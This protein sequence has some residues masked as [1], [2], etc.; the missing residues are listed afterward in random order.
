MSW[1]LALDLSQRLIPGSDCQCKHFFQ[2]LLPRVKSLLFQCV[3]R[4]CCWTDYSNI[5]Y[6]LLTGKITCGERLGERFENGLRMTFTSWG[7]FCVRNPRPVILFSVVFIAMC[8]SGFVYIKATTNPVDLW[9]APSSQARKEKEY[10]DKHFGP[11]FRTEQLIIQA[12]NSHP[13]IYSPYPSGADVPFGPPLNKDILHQVT[14]TSKAKTQT[15]L[16]G[17]IVRSCL[18]SV[19]WRV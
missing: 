15:L 1:P 14:G 13:D 11:F 18:P 6:L 4:K 2:C 17:V 8:C 5:P 19:R 16:T 10:F 3:S 9:S 12:P 7:A